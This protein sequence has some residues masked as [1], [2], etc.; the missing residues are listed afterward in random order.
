[1]SEQQE[2]PFAGG[3]RLLPAGPSLIGTD[4]SDDHPIS[5]VYDS[6]LAAAN[7]ELRSPLMLP[8]HIRLDENEQ[9]QC[10]TCHD[11]HDDSF[12]NFLVEENIMAGLCEQCHQ[13]SGWLTGSHKTSNATWNGLGPNPWPDSTYTSVMEN[14]CGNCHS[15]H[16]ADGHERLLNYSFEEDNCLVCHNS[17]VAGSDV[18]AELLKTYAHPV[19]N[20]TGIHDPTEDFTGI[21]EDHVE[22][23]DCHNPHWARADQTPVPPAVSLV[24]AGTSGI[25]TSGQYLPLVGNEYEICYKCHADNNVISVITLDRQVQQL[26][27][28]LEFDPSNPSYHPVEVQGVNANV[29]SLLPPMQS[30]D[31]IYCSDCHSS[32]NAAVTKGPH[33]SSYQYLLEEN[34]TTTDFTIESSFSYALCY[35]CHDRSNILGNNSFPQ[36]SLHIVDHNAPCSACHDAHGI[37]STQGNSINNTHLI[38]FDITI[39]QPDSQARLRFEDAGI[40]SGRCYLTCHGAVHEPRQYP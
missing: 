9:M 33:G 22:C 5:F 26:N 20:Y 12:G 30:S 29:P 23:V 31:V 4:L 28:R 10:T 19:Q 21:V 11:P 3:I 27:T 18:E 37:S 13:K 36:H 32:D 1:V 16:T 35:K 40:F 39:V 17:N 34:Y 25:N 14:G 38:N 7:E 2:I 6:G 8:S 24:N 15:T